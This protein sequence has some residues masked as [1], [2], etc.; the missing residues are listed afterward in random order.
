MADFLLALPFVLAHEGGWADDPDDP[1]GATNF[2]IT[3]ATAQR[4]G[5]Q[6]KEALSAI[7]PSQVEHI[8]RTG[9]WHFDGV[10]DQRVAG[11]IFDICVNMG[12]GAGTKLVQEALNTLG[13]GLKADGRWGPITEASVNAVMADRMLAILCYRSAEKYKAIVDAHPSS[14]KFLRGWLRRASGVPSGK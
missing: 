8:Y 7:T 10:R 2:G 1:G 3:M 13:A 9:Y 5:I 4:Y 12:V 14:G 11:K 6:T